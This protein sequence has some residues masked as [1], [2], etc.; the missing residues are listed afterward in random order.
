MYKII[1]NEYKINFFEEIILKHMGKEN[2]PF[3]CHQNIVPSVSSAPARGYIHTVKH[4]KNEYKIRLQ[5]NL[6]LNL[7]QMCK[8]IRAFC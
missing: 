7:Q 2:R 3:C 1:K 4:E 6:F 8:V 5:S